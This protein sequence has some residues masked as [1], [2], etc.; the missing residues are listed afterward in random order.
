MVFKKKYKA[1]PE[2]GV[3]NPIDANFCSNCSA[4][5]D[6]GDN[7]EQEEIQEETKIP[8]KKENLAKQILAKQIEKSVND[9]ARYILTNIPIQQKEVIQDNETGKIEDIMQSIASLRNDVNKIL[10]IL[11]G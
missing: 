8:V 9:K 6:D 7:N 2:C 3:R 10:N 5:F 11:E 1:C 4:G